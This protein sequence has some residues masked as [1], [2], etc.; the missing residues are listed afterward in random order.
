MDMDMPRTYGIKRTLAMKNVGFD[1]LRTS[2]LNP[3]GLFTSGGIKG[4][5][6]LQKMLAKAYKIEDTRKGLPKS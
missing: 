3:F 5:K 1:M 2:R 6:D 4:K